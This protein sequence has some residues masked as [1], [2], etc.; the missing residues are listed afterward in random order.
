MPWFAPPFQEWFP[1]GCGDTSWS[2]SAIKGPGA[3]PPHGREEGSET[4]AATRGRAGAVARAGRPGAATLGGLP[5]DRHEPE[6]PGETDGIPADPAGRMA[7]DRARRGEPE[8]IRT[9]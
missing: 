9:G 1:V 7:P 6:G 2:R 8:C 3:D 4:D 5:G